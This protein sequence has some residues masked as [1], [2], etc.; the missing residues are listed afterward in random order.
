VYNYVLLE[1]KLEKC[2]CLWFEFW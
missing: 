2:V 1:E